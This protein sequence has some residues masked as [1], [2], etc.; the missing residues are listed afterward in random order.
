MRCSRGSEPAQAS[1]WQ[2]AAGGDRWLLTAVG[3]YLGD[4]DPECVGQ[5]LSGTAL[6]NDLP[7]FRCSGCPA[8]ARCARVRG[9]SWL[10][11]GADGCRR[12]RHGCRRRCEPTSAS[13][14]GS[15]IRAADAAR[16]RSMRWARLQRS[17]RGR[18]QP[19]AVGGDCY[20]LGYSVVGGLADAVDIAEQC[21]GGTIRLRGCGFLRRRA[22]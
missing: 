10:R 14:A 5:V 15:R 16:R 13:G 2:V 9:C 3:E 7:L 12:C 18:T 19:L 20:S 17:R 1:C 6:S 4:A 22:V 11:Q 8:Q 21:A